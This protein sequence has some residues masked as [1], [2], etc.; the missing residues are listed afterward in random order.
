MAHYLEVFGIG[1]AL[2]L[3]SFIYT[4]LSLQYRTQ[5]AIRQHGCKPATRYMGT[6]IA[7]LRIEARK[8]GTSTEV[9]SNLHR[10]YGETFEFQN[11]GSAPE[12]TTCSP[13][14]IQAIAA[15]NFDDWGVEPFRGNR[16]EPFMGQGVLMND[17][18][19]WKHSRAMIRPTFARSEIANLDD[20]EIYLGRM[21]ALVPRDG[22]TVDLQP[23]FKKLVSA[24][25]LQLF[26]HK[27]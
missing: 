11:S 26:S 7:H 15:T 8:K 2:Y 10:A 3:F 27:G 13:K 20:F 24:I 25:L 19:I 5:K 22:S 12:L 16:T 4:F 21:L 1:L 18:E 6:D 23:L 9:M 17:G 14:N